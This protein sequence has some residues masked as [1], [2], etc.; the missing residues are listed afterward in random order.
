MQETSDFVAVGPRPSGSEGARR[1]ALYLQRRLSALGYAPIVDEFTDETPSGPVTFRN[2][3]ASREG[4]NAATVILVS[5]YD[6]PVGMEDNFVGANDGGSSTGVLLEIARVLQDSPPL[7]VDILLAF[8]DGEECQR[9]Y[10]PRDGLHGSRHLARTL[11][12][13]GRDHRVRAVIVLDMIGDSNLNIT[14]P[15]NTTPSLQAL[16]LAAARQEGARHLFTL[17]AR[18]IVDDHVP[19]LAAGMP[20]V[21][22]IDFDYGTAPG[23]NDY[24]HTSQD[25][26]DKLSEKSL[27]VVG[28]VVLRALVQLSDAEAQRTSGALPLR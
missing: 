20:A 21:N 16:I 18:Y 4:A 3:L 15:R 27:E 6:T 26:L 25:T 10:G 9:E 2:V 19:F 28:R 11:V 24:W 7:C 17:D 22:L 12:R 1:A 23:R 13:N 5:H 14:L 8:V